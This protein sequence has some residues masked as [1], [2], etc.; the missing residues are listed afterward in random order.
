[1][2]LLLPPPFPPSSVL[3]PQV[4]PQCPGNQPHISFEL[5]FKKNSP[6]CGSRSEPSRAN[7]HLAPS[8]TVSCVSQIEG[9]V[10]V[11]ICLVDKMS[12]RV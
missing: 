10:S 2:S 1:M 12:V 5:H 4:S 11:C 8:G 3:L 9:L 6:C 7:Y